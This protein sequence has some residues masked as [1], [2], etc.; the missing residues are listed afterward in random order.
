MNL[1]FV[2]ALV[3]ESGGSHMKL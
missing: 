2:W 1:A 3:V